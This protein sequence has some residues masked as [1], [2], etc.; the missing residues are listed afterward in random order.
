M[1]ANYRFQWYQHIYE[2]IPQIHEDAR[3]AGRELGTEKLNGKIGLY[4]G[5]SSCPGPLPSYVLDA[6]LEANQKPVLPMRVVEDELREL[7][8]DVYGDGYDAAVTNTCESAL[9]VSMDTLFA[10]P[11]MRRGETYRGR[12]ITPYEEDFEFFAGYG[13]PFPPR[14]KNLLID[15]SVSAGE[16]GV[17]GKSLPNLDAVTVKLVGAKYEVHG[18]RSNPVPLMS[19]TDAEASRKRLA[20][21]AERHAAELVGFATIGYDTVGYGYGEA[22]EKGVPKLKKMIGELGRAYDIPY[23]VD[24]ASCLPIIGHSPEDYGAD[25]MVWS[26]DKVGHAPI[27][28]LMVGTE[29]AMV[30]I[31]KGL[32]L[33]GERFGGASSHGKAVFSMCNPGRD[34]VVGLTKILQVLRDD[35]DRFRRSIDQMHQIIEEEFGSFEPARFREKFIFTKSY[36]MG[37]TELNYEQTWDD[38]NF[39]IPIFNLEDMVANTNPIMSALEEMG[40]FPATIYSGNMF[41]APGQGTSD[42][43]GELMEEPTRTAIRALVRA[44]EIVC[45]HAGLE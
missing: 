11:I 35:P 45:R 18:I 12:F 21:V 29:E 3:K 17:E 9:R 6:I 10:P 34:A 42:P 44:T 8:K 2:S 41:I 36:T 4:P 43:S 30:P 19:R 15:R 33:G 23:I 28:G 40:I 38:G 32:G 13:R 20:E 24:S 37:G 39:G 14:Y 26:M 31:R 1:K 5:S 22:D 16:L 25:V 27:S 7:V